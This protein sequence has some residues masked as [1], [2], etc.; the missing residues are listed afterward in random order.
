MLK[1]SDREKLHDCLL[2]VQSARTILNGFGANW[3]WLDEIH[4]CFDSA[5]EK[6]STLLRA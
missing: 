5:D 2:L 3:C 4:E 1:P 6:I